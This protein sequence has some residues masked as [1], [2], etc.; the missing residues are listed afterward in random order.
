MKKL[1]PV[2]EVCDL[3]VD[4]RFR[5][6]AVYSCSGEAM[7]RQRVEKIRSICVSEIIRCGIANVKLYFFSLAGGSFRMCILSKMWCEDPLL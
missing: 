4:I 2:V 3:L 6:P 7:L 1:L 5:R